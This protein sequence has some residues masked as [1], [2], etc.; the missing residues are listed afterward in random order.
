MK[1]K[2]EEVAEVPEGETKKSAKK[3]KQAML[4]K[5]FP[6]VNTILILTMPRVLHA[7][8]V[9]QAEASDDAPKKKSKHAVARRVMLV[10]LWH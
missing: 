9:S 5:Q 3:R 6:T 8:S 2:S 4:R 1:E 10:L 7:A